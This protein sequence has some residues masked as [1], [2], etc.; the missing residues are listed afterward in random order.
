LKKQ[1]LKHG[2]TEEAEELGDRA[3]SE[4]PGSRVI[5]VIARDRETK[6]NF[7]ADER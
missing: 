5:A 2:G 6:K 4:S 3:S 7:T 1:T